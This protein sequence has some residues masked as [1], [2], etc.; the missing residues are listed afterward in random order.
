MSKT[1]IIGKMIYRAVLNAKSKKE[2]LL[3]LRDYIGDESADAIERT[4]KQGLSEPIDDD[5]TGE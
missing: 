3:I 2:I 5:F 1:D 4:H